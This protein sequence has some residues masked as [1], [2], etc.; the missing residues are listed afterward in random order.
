MRTKLA[1][2]SF[3]D[4]Q[5][6]FAA[7]EYNGAVGGWAIE[8]AD[9]CRFLTYSGCRVGKCRASPGLAWIGIGS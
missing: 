9:F 8:T 4:V 2:P 3:S 6:I 5:R 7:I 1:L